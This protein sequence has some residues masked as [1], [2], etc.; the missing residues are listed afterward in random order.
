MAQIRR[1]RR[2]GRTHRHYCAFLEQLEPR[3]LLSTATPLGVNIEGVYDW[4]RS[5]MFV[6]AMKSARAFGSPDTP[7]DES[8]AVGP[9]GWP[10]GDFGCVILTVNTPDLSQQDFPSIAGTYHL[11]AVG[12]ADISPTGASQVT[13]SNLNYDPTT[14]ITTADV[15]VGPDATNIY[16]KFTDTDEG[17]K[18]IKLIRPGYAA[19][20]AQEFTDAFLA[21]LQDFQTLRFMDFTRTN[22][23]PIVEW[24]DRTL[25]TAPLQSADTGVAW[26]Y[27]IDLANATG[28]D[29]WINIPSQANDDYVTQLATLLKN[30]LNPGISVYLEYSNE[31]WNG[32]FQQAGWNYDAAQADVAADPSVLNYDHCDNTWDYAWRRIVVQL[33]HD[34]SLFA[35]VYGQAAINDTIRP[36]LASQ[37]GFPYVLRDQLNFMEHFYGAPSDT[38]YAIAGAPYLNLGS[39]SND[40]S[41][42]VD[43]VITALQNNLPALVQAAEQYTALA[44]YYGLKHLTYEGG[45]DIE[46]DTGGNYLTAKLPANYDPRMGEI[47]NEYLTDMYA[48]GIEQVMYYNEAGAYGT[49][50]A[51][52]LTEN[53]YNLSGYKFAAI[54]AFVNQPPPEV[55]AGTLLPGS[56]T[57]GTLALDAGAYI[58][59]QWQNIGPGGEISYVGTGSSYDYLLKSVDGVDATLTLNVASGNACDVQVFL[60]GR[61]L[62]M[63]NIP[64]TG[65]ETA[66]LTVEL[67]IASVGFHTLRLQVINGGFA[68]RTLTFDVAAVAPTQPVPTGLS[69]T[70]TSP[71]QVDLSWDPFPNQTGAYIERS[72][73]G[74]TWTTIGSTIKPGDANHDGYVDLTDLTILT[75]LWQQSVTPWTLA[76]FDGSGFVDLTDLTILTG[77]WQ[78]FGPVVYNA[79][80]DTTVEPG[81]TYYY[82]VRAVTAAGTS[83]Y[84]AVVSVTALA[85]SE[86]VNSAAAPPLGVLPG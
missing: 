81:T 60:D 40:P 26:E 34:V 9:D 55:T 15:I 53:I 24:S 71:S 65:G 51:W 33:E 50:G 13:V 75:G 7:W 68:M 38:I 4:Q 31:V 85:P 14:N 52:G 30:T 67:P 48:A 56:A 10:T 43:Q 22:D 1:R 54:T 84:S 79:F 29:M 42:T 21:S 2:Q 46:G 49:W 82:R 78:S 23:N 77:N 32:G 47:I 63:L 73:D 76:D 62:T 69:A 64:D 86:L 45:L 39:A 57:G 61:E 3:A 28:K 12:K 19:D 36:V 17:L 70:S 44:A 20:T 72:T 37:I 35:D 27:A 59:D 74:V 58:A 16:L 80:R 8:A 18:D 11:S 41:L 25:P 5:F 83:G 6:D 66:C